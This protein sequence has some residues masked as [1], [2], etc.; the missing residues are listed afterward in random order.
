MNLIRKGAVVAATA[1]MA[2]SVGATTPAAAAGA[3]ADEVHR[4]TRGCINYSWGDGSVTW[5]VYYSNTCNS[6]QQFWVKTGSTSV[7]ETCI[8][9]GAKDKGNKVF[10]NKPLNFANKDGRC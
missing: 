10:Y 1:A 2:L 9:V 5:T 7:F 8:T 3:A 6:T 4:G